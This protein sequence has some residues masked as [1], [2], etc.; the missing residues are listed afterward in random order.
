MAEMGYDHAGACECGSKE[1]IAEHVITSCPIYHHPNGSCALLD[2][3]KSLV[4][5]LTDTSSGLLSAYFPQTKEENDLTTITLLRMFI[6][7]L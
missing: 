6:T 7:F 5:W 2:V 3:D 4:P 1:Q